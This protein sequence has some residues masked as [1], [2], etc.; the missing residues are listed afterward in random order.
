MRQPD[1]KTSPMG[2]YRTYDADSNRY[3]V[4]LAGEMAPLYEYS[5]APTNSLS[6]E[7][8]QT[9]MRSELVVDS[10]SRAIWIWD[11]TQS[12]FHVIEKTGD[13]LIARISSFPAETR[14]NNIIFEEHLN[15]W[16][17]FYSLVPP[18]DYPLT[19]VL[20]IDLLAE[21]AAE[22]FRYYTIAGEWIETTIL[23][24]KRGSVTINGSIVTAL[25]ARRDALN[26]HSSIQMQNEIRDNES[27]RFR[28]GGG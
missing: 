11:P 20:Y 5:P 15:A 25:D 22:G 4:Y 28:L 16:V 19:M 2:A 24:G 23:R 1:S 9:W 13:V 21:R 26:R 12:S 27:L 3:S 14:V 18:D 17:E 6:F 8:L 10:E 7:R